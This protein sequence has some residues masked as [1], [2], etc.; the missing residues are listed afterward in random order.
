MIKNKDKEIL[1]R[2][3]MKDI[4]R[5]L[6]GS[7]FGEVDREYKVP[8]LG[9]SGVQLFDKYFARQTEER[10]AHLESNYDIIIFFNRDL[11]ELEI[12]GAR[13]QYE[14]TKQKENKSSTTSNNRSK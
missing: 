10:K 7:D 8:H 4:V 9:Y 12:E 14:R 1:A 11:K 5:T 3:L 6:N 13:K 2:I